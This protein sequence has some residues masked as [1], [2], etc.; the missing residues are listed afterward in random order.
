MIRPQVNEFLD[1]MLR[2]K[3]KNLRIEEAVIP[4]DSDLMNKKL[5]DTWIRK[6]TSLLVVAVKHSGAGTYTY[7]PG[8]DFVIEKGTILILLGT[9]DDVNKLREKL[10]S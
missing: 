7:N 1:L 4:D 2:D 5:Q 9:S 10:R 8:P 6:I 3:D